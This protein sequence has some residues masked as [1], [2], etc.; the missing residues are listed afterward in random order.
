HVA[1]GRGIHYCLGAPLARLEGRI[2]LLTLLNRFP[3]LQLAVP[4]EV[5]KWHSGVIFR[6]L[7][8]LPLRF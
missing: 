6:G 1:F 3:D 5:L 7:E 4:A 2:A 8:Q